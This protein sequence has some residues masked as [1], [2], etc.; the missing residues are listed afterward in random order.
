MRHDKDNESR[1]RTPDNSTFLCC[2]LFPLVQMPLHFKFLNSTH[3]VLYLV[4]KCPSRKKHYL[5]CTNSNLSCILLCLLS[6]C[7]IIICLH[8][9]F[10]VWVLKPGMIFYSI[11]YLAD[12]LENMIFKY[13]GFFFLMNTFF[14][15]GGEWIFID[16]IIFG[17]ERGR[18]IPQAWE[19]CVK[20]H[21]EM[22]NKGLRQGWR[23]GP[24]VSVFSKHVVGMGSYGSKSNE[25]AEED[26]VD[27]KDFYKST[28]WEKI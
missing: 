1:F 4:F 20:R 11:L 23:K 17:K 22:G 14:R 2:S 7:I 16:E 25:I 26:Q 18:N 21:K 15:G 8:I 24:S 5:F 28:F 12:Y 6:H 27:N 19:Q 10:P 9:F 13:K 3:P